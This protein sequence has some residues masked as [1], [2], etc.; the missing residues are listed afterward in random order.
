MSSFTLV[1]GSMA[2]DSDFLDLFL[3]QDLISLYLT[4]IAINIATISF[5]S[6]SIESLRNRSSRLL[7]DRHLKAPVA[8][9]RDTYKEMNKILTEQIAILI[10]SSIFLI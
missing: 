1:T 2:L 6:N 8:N 7:K 5:I 10:L 3:N 4:L 9:F